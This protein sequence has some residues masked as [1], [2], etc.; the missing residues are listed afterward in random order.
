[1]AKNDF[2]YLDD[3]DKLNFF[4]E[5]GHLATIENAI[6]VKWQKHLATDITLKQQSGQNTKKIT[7]IW[8]PT[9]RHSGHYNHH[10]S[11]QV[12]RAVLAKVSLGSDIRVPFF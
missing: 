1:M 4:K 10:C 7:A 8:P 11:S 6:G 5:F 9:S 3:L 2:S 12:T